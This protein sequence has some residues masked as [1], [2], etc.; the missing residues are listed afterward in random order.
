MISNSKMRQTPHD[1]ASEEAQ[2]SSKFLAF[3]EK[4]NTFD[5]L[6]PIMLGTNINADNTCKTGLQTQEFFGDSDSSAKKP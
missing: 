2:A 5:L 4:A 6:I 1:I 3:N